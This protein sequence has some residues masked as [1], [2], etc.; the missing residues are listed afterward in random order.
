MQLPLTILPG[1]ICDSQM[2][3]AQIESFAGAQCVDGF[4]G[5]ADRLEDMALYALERM[6]D[7]SAVLG[8][9]MGS[10]V[11]L[12]IYRIAP[13]RIAR[14]AMADTGVH[15]PRPGEREKRYALRDLGRAEGYE[16]LVDE[17]L[18]P[19][20]GS[21]HRDNAAIRE[22]LRNM[23][24]SAGQQVFEAQINALLHRPELDSLLPTIDCP[25]TLVAGEEDEWAPVDQHRQ[26]A[27]AIPGA[28]LTILPRAGHMAPIEQPGSF[29]QA[30]AD[31][32]AL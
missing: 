21:S 13:E 30:L 8:H 3:A 20:I 2:F 24:L 19:M 10:R 32:L 14:L 16:A 1:L 5:G 7:R 28:R 11:A 27:E 12:E 23:C 22:C 6:P 15:Q 26:I 17:W 9:S 18:P 25:V 31:W 4:Y 29:N